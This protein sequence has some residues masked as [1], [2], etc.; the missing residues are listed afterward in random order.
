[1]IKRQG[2]EIFHSKKTLKIQ[3]GSFIC[4]KKEKKK[5]FLRGRKVFNICSHRGIV[6]Q[7]CLTETD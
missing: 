1:M 2:M 4:Q 3:T 5:N 6:L 7:Y